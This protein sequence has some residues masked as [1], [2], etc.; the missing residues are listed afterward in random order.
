MSDTPQAIYNKNVETLGAIQK[1]AEEKYDAILTTLGS[2]FLALSATFIKDVVPLET[3]QW[4]WVLYLSWVAFGLTIILTVISLG[5][6]YSAV[7]W[8]M[9]RLSPKEYPNQDELQRNPWSRAIRYMNIF[10]GVAFILGVVLTVTFVVSN[11]V[12]WR[13]TME[14]RIPSQT[15]VL[16]KG[17]TIPHMQTGT[18]QQGS[19]GNTSQS[20]G[21]GGQGSGTGGNTGTS[22]T[23]NSSKGS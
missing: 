21:G 22:N 9:G 5:A 6:G 1:A 10:S 11:I 8:H 18:T 2:G 7:Q 20:G 17:L 13:S 23:G 16:Q 4:L 14:K 12:Y 19:S 15:E 3:A